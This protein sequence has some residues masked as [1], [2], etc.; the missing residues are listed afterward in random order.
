MNKHDTLEDIAHNGDAFLFC[1]WLIENSSIPRREIV[2]SYA[3][4]KWKY[5]KGIADTNQAW[6]EWANSGMAKRFRAVY[7]D[8]LSLISIYT[9]LNI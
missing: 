9:Q 8:D 2:Q 6:M 3:V 5:I 4:W 7:S 1:E